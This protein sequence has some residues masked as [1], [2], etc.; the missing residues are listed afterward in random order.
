MP[1]G[2]WKASAMFHICMMPIFSDFLM[3]FMEVFMDDFSVFG[4][5]I[6]NWLCNQV[7]VLKQY[8][9][10]NLV[11][12]WEKNRFIVREGIILAC[13]LSSRH[14]NGQSQSGRYSSLPPPTT[15]RQISTFL[16]MLVF[17]GNSSKDFSKILRPLCNLL[18]K[19]VVVEMNDE[20]ITAFKTLKAALCTSPHYCC[21]Q[22]ELYSN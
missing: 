3:K 9:K 1:S 14:G 10:T 12:S 2:L 16:E 21:T 15:S 13:C 17:T 7:L 8:T 22:L 6:K 4:P 19:N 11:L 20:C 5:S 18:L